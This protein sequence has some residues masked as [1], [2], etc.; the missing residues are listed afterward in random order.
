MSSAYTL[1]LRE[2]INGYAQV[3]A[4]AI[5]NGLTLKDTEAVYRGVVA[6][7]VAFGKSQADIDAIVTATTQ[8]LSKGKLSAEELS[9]QLGER[10]PGAVARFAQA[11]GRSLPE[12]SQALKDGKVSI[13]DFVTFAKKQGTDYD[14]IARLIGSSPE[15][16]GARLSLALTRAGETYGTFLQ[17]IGAKIQDFLTTTVNLFNQN[18]EFIKRFLFT[19]YTTGKAV[20]EFTNTMSKAAVEAVNSAFPLMR[21]QLE[22]AKLIYRQETGRDIST[23]FAA[24][25]PQ[26]DAYYKKNKEYQAFIKEYFPEFTPKIFGGTQPSAGGGTAEGDT[27]EQERARKKREEDAKVAAE[28]QQRYAESLVNQQVRY[29]ETLF[30]IQRDLDEQRYQRLRELENLRYENEQRN[31][32]GVQRDFAAA[33]NRY[34]SSLADIDRALVT[35]RLRVTEAQLKV[36]G[37]T[38]IEAVVSR[39]SSQSLAGFTTQQLSAATATAARFTGIANMCAESVRAFYKSLGISLPG[40]TAWADTV[41]EAGTVM[42]DWSKLQPGD[43]V[44]KGR[45]GDTTH[46]GVYTGGGDV[47]HQSRSRGLRAGNYPDLGYF[48]SGP[49]YFV[50]PSAGRMRSA[51]ASRL[52]R[53]V[54]ETG[55]VGIANLNLGAAQQSEAEQQR[56]AELQRLEVRKR[57]INDITESISQQNYE[58]GN[59]IDLLRLRQRL[60]AQGYDSRALDLEEKRFSLSKK[61]N[62]SKE[63]A[64]RLAAENPTM[65][66][67]IQAD[68]TKQNSA[69]AEQLRLIEAL[70]AA[71]RDAERGYGF[72]EGA[73]RY[74][75]SIG[76]MKEATAQLTVNGI[77]GLETA[78]LDLSTTG[79]ANFQSFA[80][81]LLK[82]TAKI[83]L[84]Q[85]VLKPLIQGLASLFNPAAAAVSSAA[86]S[87]GSFAGAFGGP[88]WG[89]TIGAFSARGNAFNANGIVPFAMGGMVTNPTLF[90]Y[91]NGGVPGLGLMGEAGPEAILPLRRGRDGRLGVSAGGGQTNVTVNVDASGS[92]VSGDQGQ[93]AALGRAVAQAVQQELIKQRRPGGLIAA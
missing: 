10:L 81:E 56:N 20:M 49:A 19:L 75:E 15:K 88:I 48:Q 42:T 53:A 32:F 21:L 5:A 7:A 45:P 87:A 73:Q 83:I 44:A 41:R 78:L 9:G 3:S 62:E 24:P 29:A 28:Q 43:I 84:Q 14:A 46:V 70:N 18:E 11:T 35:S 65:A 93:S 89:G 61:M 6:S 91:A 72:R 74:I 34:K 58:L 59:E 17:R 33:F 22:Y 92:S 1:G 8:V 39:G 31:L 66:A 30:N 26:V 50:R 52:N 13:A 67:Q 25:N 51:E 80:A 27:K 63:I 55:D 23:L 82:Q 64:N 54:R 77:Q 86:S 79:T 76:S 4:A 57:F 2:T 85:L 71:Q 12:L 60:Q 40:V 37:A 90:R 69:Y 16:A 38:Q 68:L 36:Q 47:F